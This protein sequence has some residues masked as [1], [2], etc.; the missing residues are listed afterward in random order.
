MWKKNLLILKKK[1]WILI[2]NIIS[3]IPKDTS[4]SYK[5]KIANKDAGRRMQVLE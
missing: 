5:S 4:S 1:S 2:Q 3:K